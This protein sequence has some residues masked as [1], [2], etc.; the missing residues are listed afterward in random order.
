MVVSVERLR[1]YLEVEQEGAAIIPDHRPPSQWPDH[2]AVCFSS[3]STRYRPDL[4]LVLKKVSFKIKPQEKVGIVGRT[5]AGKSSLA[6]ALFRALE[7]EDG[8]IVIDN[9]DISK[10]GLED[11]RQA[12]T[13]V[14][15]GELKVL[16]K[17]D[18]LLI[19]FTRPNFIH[20][21]NK[22]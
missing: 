16:A 18:T 22:E 3:Y 9:V 21:H 10:I 4:D 1:E 6:L 11:L 12:I 13:M 15:Q 7:A 14:P 5:G 20:W 2:G 8:K 17:T 19:L